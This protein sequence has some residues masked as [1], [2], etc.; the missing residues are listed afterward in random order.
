MIIFATQLIKIIR[1]AYR[2]LL[3]HKKKIKDEEI[4]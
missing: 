4:E 3:L 2:K 1:K